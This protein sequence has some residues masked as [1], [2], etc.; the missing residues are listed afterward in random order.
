MLSLRLRLN[1]LCSPSWS[2]RGGRWTNGDNSIRPVESP[3]LVSRLIYD[4]T[5]RAAVITCEHTGALVPRVSADRQPVV[6]ADVRAAVDQAH[7]VSGDYLTID[8]QP[9]RAV[10]TAGPFGTAPLY[11]TAR[12]DV[13]LGS[14]HLPDLAPFVQADNLVDRAVARRLARQSRYTRETVLADVQ[15]LTERAT[16]TFTG[17]GLSLS[18]PEPAEHVL[19]S[20]RVR[21]GV[22]VVAVFGEL[23]ANVLAGSPAADGPVGV[24]LSGGAD[25][26]NVALALAAMRD[27]PVPSYGLILSGVVGQQQRHRRAAMI[28]C[29]GLRDTAVRA[30][31][32]P[33]FAVTGLRRRGVPHDPT[34]AYYREAFDA[35][36]DAVA[37]GGSRIVCTGLGGDE[38]VARHPQEWTTAPPSV[39][40][41]PWL[42]PAARAGLSEVDEGVAP[43]APVPMTV[44]M[45]QATHNP[46]YLAAGIWP[47][48]PLAHPTLVRFTEQLPVEWRVGKRLLR[49]RLRRRGLAAD[50]I[51]PALPETFS[52]LMQAG[53]RR[54]GLSLLKDMLRESL[55]VDLGYLDHNALAR[56]YASAGT[57]AAI[58]STLCDAISL[59][60]GLRSFDQGGCRS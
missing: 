49:E 42:G 32:H 43:I 20:R 4:Q 28:E 11:L 10:L 7:A 58:P 46:A 17:A 29:F 56:A 21:P 8:L 41:V 25:S 24:E 44:L 59:E 12:G 48:A 54:Y 9:E 22:D 45:A 39:E 14:W 40:V 26:A 34:A 52:A 33:P 31:D 51:D 57:A 38:L 3:A 50:V 36:R 30:A 35:L 1:E 27:E 19:R 53:L 2:W 47:V 16:A 23:L 55:L 5:G 6:V 13:L 60:V 18:Y 15:R 37:V